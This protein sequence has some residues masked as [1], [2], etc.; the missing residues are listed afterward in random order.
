[1][2]VRIKGIKRTTVKGHHYFYHRAT[3]TRITA[4]PNTVEFAAEVARLDRE[5]SS[6]IGISKDGP[7]TWNAL[8]A[9]FKKSPEYARLA[10]RTK[11]DYGKVFSY[12]EP[13]GGILV[14]Q[15]TGPVII[16]IRDKAFRQKKWR[17]TNHLLQ[18]VGRVMNWGKPR[19]LSNGYP[20]KG[21]REIKLPRPTDMP[22]ANRPWT[23]AE[24]DVVLR[25]ADGPLK[26][27]IALGMFAAMRVEDAA[28]VL[29]S[30]YG[31]RALEDGRVIKCLEWRQGKT[32]DEVWMPAAPELQEILDAAPRAAVTI[33]A[34]AHGRPIKKAWLE[35]WF[36]EHIV[37]LEARSL[38][39]PGLTFHGM[40]HTH[41]KNLADLGADPRMI[42]S[43]LGHRSMAASLHYSAQA[44]RRR[45]ATAAV[46]L[47]A[48]HR[49]RRRGRPE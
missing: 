11:S 32:G 25:E 10:E 17:F 2:I 15:M 37:S 27:A 19:G 42:Q 33:V 16:E 44:S 28:S 21:D 39:A 8:V 14:A 1:V 26:C 6:R 13:S 30:I 31:E 34:G 5:A 9:E 49:S 3:K 43:L 24:C 18:V 35:K 4:P 23:D 48:K 36:H 12:L 41:G 7:G 45:G 20:L 47:L 40:R 46:E 38:V 29:W 22:K